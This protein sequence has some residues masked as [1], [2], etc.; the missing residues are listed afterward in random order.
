MA[1]TA[2]PSATFPFTH[3]NTIAGT[4]DKGGVLLAPGIDAAGTTWPAGTT[5]PAS[6]VNYAAEVFWPGVGLNCNVCHVDNSYQNDRG[7]LGAV[8]LNRSSFVSGTPVSDPWSWMVIS[9]KAASCTACHDSPRSIG[10]VNS[11][12]NATFGNLTQNAWPQETCD[13]CHANGR[14]MGVDR[15]HGLN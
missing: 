3:G 13:D 8:V 9:P 5:F 12:G 11:F 10:H 6:V 1:S 14:F 7:P 2:T 15:V 4:F